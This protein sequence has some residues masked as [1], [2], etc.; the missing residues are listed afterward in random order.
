MSVNYTIRKATADDSAII[1]H[2]RIGMFTDMGIDPARIKPM[3]AP[4][5]LWVNEEFGAGRFETWFACAED[6]E[7]IAGAGLWLYQWIPSP[8]APQTVR[9]YI[10]NVYTEPEYRKQGIARRLIE[11]ILAYC[12]ANNLLTVLLHASR[13]GRPIYEALDFKPTNEMRLDV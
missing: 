2:H 4:F 1:V 5:R 10:L 3:E 8:L 7:V 12:R 9:A 11:E 6:G 13:Q